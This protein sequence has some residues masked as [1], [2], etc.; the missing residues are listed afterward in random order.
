MKK[1]VVFAV[2]FKALVDKTSQNTVLSTHW[3]KDCVNSDVL[4]DLSLDAAKHRK[5][6]SVFLSKA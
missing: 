6:Q 3:L 4:D 2:H 5:N 1:T